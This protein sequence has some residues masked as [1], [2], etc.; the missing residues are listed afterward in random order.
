[1]VLLLTISFIIHV[2]QSLPF[3]LIYGDRYIIILVMLFILVYV[4]LRN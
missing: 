3:N 4:F 2:I 1:M